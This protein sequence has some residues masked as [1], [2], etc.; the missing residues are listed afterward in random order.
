VNIKKP[1][2]G[3]Y[4]DLSKMLFKDVQVQ[5]FQQLLQVFQNHWNHQ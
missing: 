2:E 3:G 1:P 4:S 5:L